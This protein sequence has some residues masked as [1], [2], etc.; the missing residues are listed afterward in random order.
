MK[1]KPLW[2]GV[3]TIAWYLLF[4]GDAEA[5]GPVTHVH[6]GC[7]ILGGLS[8]LA[9][10]LA[11]L[12]R[13]NSEAYLYGNIAADVIIAKNLAATERHCHNWD[14][15]FSVLEEATNDSQR[16]FA[17]GYLSHLAAD[18][19]A[20]NYFVPWKL[21]AGFPARTTGHAYWEIRLDQKAP[22]ESWELA[23]ELTRQRF[24]EHHGLL[25]RTI[26]GTI[27]RFETN[28]IF[29]N[30]M[31]LVQRMKRWRSWL[32]RVDKRSPWVLTPHE[33]DE[34]HSLAVE[35]IFD[36]LTHQRES[37][38][39]KSDPTGMDNLHLAKKLRTA[40]RRQHSRNPMRTPELEQTLEEIRLH[41]HQS[42][43]TPT[44]PDWWPTNL[45]KPSRPLRLR[46][47]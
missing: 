18:V 27:F 5:F 10:S 26:E 46:Q 23:Q 15:G 17:W 19:V 40:L 3:H 42:I 30:G 9:P 29:F 33:A 20:H 14:V 12:L 28:V 37:L 25:S 8:L 38:T 45:E 1:Y 39:C 11:E 43:Y 34:L 21:A 22:N 41:Y 47:A 35:A 24:S 4:T 32:D 7:Q 44:S 36:M 2:L 6:L 16:A 13:K 31:L